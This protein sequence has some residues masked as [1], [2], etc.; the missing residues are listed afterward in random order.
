MSRPTRRAMIGGLAAAATVGWTAGRAVAA[1]VE[2]S[3]ERV[4]PGAELRLRCPGAQA[5]ELT[6]G[7][8]PTR[9]VPAVGGRV[10]VAVPRGWNRSAWTALRIVPTR[11]GRPAGPPAEV[12]V[13]TRSPIFGG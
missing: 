8:T 11:E 4:R 12:Q 1:A 2:V 5:F 7:A 10:R 13:F 6:F 9:V 3:A